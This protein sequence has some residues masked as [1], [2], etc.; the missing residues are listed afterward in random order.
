M[1]AGN[2]KKASRLTSKVDKATN[3]TDKAL[4]KAIQHKNNIEAGKFISEAKS[5]GYTVTSRKLDRVSNTGEMF[6]AQVL[7]GVLGGLI[8]GK[9]SEG[10]YY[11]VK[12]NPTYREE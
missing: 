2:W 3:K 10:K 8:V 1:E 7:A 12:K 9:T 4:D 6:A 11:K 5:K